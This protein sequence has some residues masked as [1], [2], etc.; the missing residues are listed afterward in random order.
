MAGREGTPE[1]QGSPPGSLSGGRAVGGSAPREKG[2]RCVGTG[3]WQDACEQGGERV[4]PYEERVPP[5]GEKVPPYGE[6]EAQP[7]VGRVPCA[8]ARDPGGR[9]QGSETGLC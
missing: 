8:G 2:G 7:C 6:K 1:E 5:C 3:S 4:P 9:R